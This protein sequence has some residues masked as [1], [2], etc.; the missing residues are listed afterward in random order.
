MSNH[1]YIVQRVLLATA[2]KTPA[3]VDRIFH[4]PF[5]NDPSDVLIA[6]I[7]LNYES[8]VLDLKILAYGEPGNIQRVG[9]GEAEEIIFF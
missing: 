8:L 9:H 6:K 5:Y 4:I 7:K 2:E 1:G 3:Q